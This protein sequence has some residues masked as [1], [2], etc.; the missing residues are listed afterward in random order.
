MSDIL[1][2]SSS[3]AIPLNSSLLLF[4][5]PLFQLLFYVLYIITTFLAYF[6]YFFPSSLDNGFYYAISSII[7]FY[8]GIFAIPSET[9][10]IY[11]A[12]LTLDKSKAL[13]SSTQTNYYIFAIKLPSAKKV[14]SS[15]FNFFFLFI[16]LPIFS[17]II[18]YFQIQLFAGF[19]FLT[20]M[21]LY[22]F[23]PQQLRRHFSFLYTKL[24]IFEKGI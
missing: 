15:L 5:Y 2:D 4:K 19:T 14:N 22:W 16:F 6:S 24:P 3:N 12:E 17:L 20:I 23:M 18:A 10:R 21:F 8:L 7:L 1:L 13:V 11:Y 9:N